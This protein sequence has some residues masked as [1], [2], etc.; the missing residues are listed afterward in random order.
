[1]ATTTSTPKSRASKAA[2]PKPVAVKTVADVAPAEAVIMAPE[3]VVIQEIPAVALPV[4][5]P[6][7]SQ[8]SPAE[9]IAVGQ[10]MEKMM[11]FTKEQMEKTAAAAK[12]QFEKV[13]TVARKNYDEMAV[14]GKANVDAVVKAGAIYAKGVEEFSRAMMGLSQIHYE[15]TMTTAKAVMGA[16]SL[17]QVIDLQS[18]FAKTA[19]DKTLAE[20][21]KLSELARKVAT[22]T[23]EPI[24]ARVTVAVEKMGKPLAA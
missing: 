15:T 20:T 24:Q 21:T 10:P 8:P 11:T 23:M 13:T 22:E 12:D 5:Q 17:R 2:S 19:V 18:E 4:A 6:P 3:P 16:T 14:F 1:M 7:E 9:A